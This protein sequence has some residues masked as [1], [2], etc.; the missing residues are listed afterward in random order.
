LTGVLDLLLLNAVKPPTWSAD[1]SL[2]SIPA[3]DPV[4]V[5]AYHQEV[6]DPH[7]PAIDEVHQDVGRRAGQPSL[8]NSMSTKSMGPCMALSIMVAS[9]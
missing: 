3:N 2:T 7:D 8:A 4:A 5:L 1:R 6:V 9:R